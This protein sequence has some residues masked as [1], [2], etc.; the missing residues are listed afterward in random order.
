[1]SSLTQLGNPAQSLSTNEPDPTSYLPADE[2][3]Y[4]SGV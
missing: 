4:E 3:L 2:A 1:M